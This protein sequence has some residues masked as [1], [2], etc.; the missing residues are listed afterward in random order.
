[1]PAPFSPRLGLKLAFRRGTSG[2]LLATFVVTAAGIPLPS[3]GR[4]LKNG[5]L[6]PCM[7]SGCGCDS[8]ERCWRSC[9][10]HTLTERLAWARKQGV[11]PPAFAIAK[12]KRAGAELSWLADKDDKNGAVKTK[13]CCVAKATNPARCTE[14]IVN[15]PATTGRACCAVG[16]DKQ[17][18][19]AGRNVAQH[20]VA[21]QALKCGGQSMNWLAA[22][23]TL[24]LARPKFSHQLPLVARLGPALSET[25]CCVS[26]DPA[27]PPPERA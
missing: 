12:A 22:V 8:A 17:A 14:H 26:D 21:W 2:L 5:E 10:C 15:V 24:L 6:Y 18:E 1:M 27:V 3:A 11:R 7:T 25:A 4:L 13:S 20:I 23:P 16:H 9:C 19:P